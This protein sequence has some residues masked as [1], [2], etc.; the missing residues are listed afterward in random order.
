MTTFKKILFYS[1]ILFTCVSCSKSKDSNVEPNPDPVIP[2]SFSFSALKVNGTSAG[3]T[4]KGINTSPEIKISFSEALNKITVANTVTLKTQGGTNVAYDATYE[5]GDKTIVIKPSEPLQNLTRYNVAVSTNLKSVK[6][7]K[8]Q[9]GVTVQLLTEV[10]PVNKFPEISDDE[11]LTLVQRQTFKYFWDFG[12]PTSGMARERNTSGDIVTTGGSGFGIMGIVAGINRGFISRTQGLERLQKIVGFLKTADK[13]HGAFPHWLNG[14]TGRV[15]PFS[16]K[17]NGADLVETGFLM[18][19]LLTARQ[20]FNGAGAAETTLRND[21]NELWN[22][23]EWHWFRRGNQN[24]LYWHWSP[25]F[26]WDMNM[27]I[28]GWNEALIVYV[29]AASSNTH[30]IPKAV[31]DEGWAGNGT[32]KNGATF[33]GTQ[34]PLGPAQGGPLFFEHYSFLGLNPNGL[35]DAYANYETQ[36]KAHT[37]INRAYSVANPKGYYGYSENCWGLTAS[38]INGGYTASSP[39]NDVGVIAPTAALSSMPYTP[40]ESMKALKFFYYKLGD[41]LWGEYGFYDAFS[42]EQ[43]WFANSYLAIDQGPILVMIENYRSKLLWNLF[44]SAPEVKKGL[45]DMGFSGPGI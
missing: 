25:N 20:Y 2:A 11:L 41:K 44:M 38:D 12:H 18:E 16:D 27:P 31:Y 24:V 39:T 36:T 19:G 4:Y 7:S 14:N 23:V 1:V 45:K 13:F 17:D 42:L 40:E 30:A 8:L 22:G 34:L 21:I 26:N 10:D 29:L 35:S 3:F 32:I 6:D 28:K 9:T 5:D 37:L 33:Y 43:P 15:Q